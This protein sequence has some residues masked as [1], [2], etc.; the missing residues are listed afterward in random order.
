[1]LRQRLVAILDL[2]SGEEETFTWLL[3]YLFVFGAA[4]S[5]GGSVAESI[6][7]SRLGVAWLPLFFIAA[8]ISV[9]FGSFVYARLGSRVGDVGRFRLI[10]GGNALA[11]LGVHWISQRGG[12]GAKL[13]PLILY[14][15]WYVFMQ[16]GFLHFSNFQRRYLDIQQA[17]RL[18]PRLLAGQN[19]GV[20]LGGL[21]VVALLRVL[22]T[23]SLVLAWAGALMAALAT[24]E[25][26]C[27]RVPAPQ[28]AG[29]LQLSGGRRETVPPSRHPLARWMFLFAALSFFTMRTFEFQANSVIARAYPTEQEMAAF[30]GTFGAVARIASIALQLGALPVGIARL[31]L[32]G[33][34]LLF[35][36]YAFGAGVALCWAPGLGAALAARFAHNA[37]AYTVS[38]P[39]VTLLFG[40]LPGNLADAVVVLTSGLIV[41]VASVAVSTLLLLLTWA[42]AT[43]VL[44][45][46]A[47]LLSALLLT[48]TLRLRR[49][50]SSA[51]LGLLRRRA[52][53]ERSLE[54]LDISRLPNAFYES[55]ESGLLSPNPQAARLTVDLLARCTDSRGRRQLGKLLDRPVDTEVK[56]AVF[57]SFLVSSVLRDE[58]RAVV[59]AG[60]KSRDTPVLAAAVGALGRLPGAEL[61]PRLVEYL[62]HAE[63]L[64]R[65]AAASHCLRANRDRE[66]ALGVVWSALKSHDPAI[67]ETALRTVPQQ[68]RADAVPAVRPMSAHAEHRVRLAALRLLAEDEPGDDPAAAIVYVPALKD[69]SAEVRWC[70]LRALARV[71]GPAA[72][73]ALTDATADPFPWVASEAVN[74]LADRKNNDHGLLERLAA[75][76]GQA[77]RRRRWL[78][79][80]LGR[81][82][83]R[84]TVLRLGRR[85]LKASF[86]SLGLRQL[87]VRAAPDSPERRYFL[88][89]LDERQ[90]QHTLMAC[91]AVAAITRPDVFP[92]LERKLFDPTTRGRAEA[93][94]ALLNLGESRLTRHIVWLLESRSDGEKLEHARAAFG[95]G[96]PDIDLAA[97]SIYRDGDP[98]LLSAWLLLMR[99][100]SWE[101]LLAAAPDYARHSHKLVRGTYRFVLEGVPC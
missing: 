85:E 67:L 4:V 53:E 40:G 10:L 45:A 58:E 17:K 76:W 93:M 69:R 51:V 39:V 88:D 100:C 32:A 6:F 73:A 91:A 22:S 28:S 98:F 29:V 65:L 86:Q 80:L 101:P 31:G 82:G 50:Y 35:P 3:A 23:E 15:S 33:A 55:L 66:R 84:E 37:L 21:V 34:A 52:G 81:L 99:A 11:A 49:V 90:R 79:E 61:D 16:L 13:A 9:T 68:D 97:A 5:L 30:Y 41:P 74:R 20:V 95:L 19:V 47:W 71:P 7:I 87:I 77:A 25:A 63:P 60:L 14:W 75:D 1:M 72:L 8:D 27:M 38:D 44:P 56:A 2:R 54:L 92:L 12:Q 96:A 36:A 64:V 46:I 62:G 43:V 48:H 78:L 24:V 42:K 70:A 57:R 18:L 94:E 59:Q 83:Q 89:V 26:L